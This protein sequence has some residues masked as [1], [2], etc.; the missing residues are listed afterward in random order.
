MM[1]LGIVSSCMLWVLTGRRLEIVL[2]LCKGTDFHSDR[3]VIS[4]RSLLI[5][6]PGKAQVNWHPRSVAVQMWWS[7]ED[8]A[9]P[10]A[11]SSWLPAKHPRGCSSWQS[12]PASDGNH[13]QTWAAAPWKPLSRLGAKQRSVVWSCWCN[14]FQLRMLLS[15]FL[16]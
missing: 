8:A 11:S 12:R 1:T 4:Q 15:L 5:F 14:S 16:L 2:L 3:L 10:H 13:N 7:V 6:L 9:L